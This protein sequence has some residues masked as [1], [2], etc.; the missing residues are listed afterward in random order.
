MNEALARCLVAWNLRSDGGFSVLSFE[1]A[2]RDRR[3]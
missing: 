2:I 3:D 1:P